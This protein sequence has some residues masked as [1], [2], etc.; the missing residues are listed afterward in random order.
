MNIPTIT[1]CVKGDASFK[2]FR[3]GKFYYGCS[4]GF[5]FPI[6]VSDTGTAT[7]LAIDKGLYFMRWIRKY[8]D[9]LTQE[10]CAYT[11]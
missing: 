6:P 8:I 5:I 3:D 4:N 7:F 10:N 1:E 11:H 9:D 2:Y